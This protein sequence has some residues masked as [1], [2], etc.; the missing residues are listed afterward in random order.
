MKMATYAYLRKS[1]S[2]QLFDR[3][4]HLFA[5]SSHEPDEYIYDTISGAKAKR[6]GLDDLKSRL[7]SGDTLIVASLTRL[8][9]TV[10]Q[11]IS[12]VA[13][14]N[15]LGVNFISL[16]EDIDLSTATGKLMFHVFAILAEFERNT[17][18]ERVKAGQAAAKAKG[19]KF[20]RK[21]AP[22]PK[23]ELEA[24][25]ADRRQ[26]MTF[27]ELSKKY[28]RSHGYYFSLLKSSPLARPNPAEQKQQ[29]S[30]HSRSRF[31]YLSFSALLLQIAPRHSSHRAAVYAFLHDQIFKKSRGT[32][33]TLSLLRRTFTKPPAERTYYRWLAALRL[34]VSTFPSNTVFIHD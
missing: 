25:R 31:N 11:L 16:K 14:F 7:V 8:G 4:Q 5:I 10:T 30:D 33:A 20:G 17:I 23:A 24:I 19:V 13:L 3:Q 28:G 15:R 1:L 29:A 21:P 27:K 18:S 2:K 26:G 9:R 34:A 12:D 6:P 32:T 22:M